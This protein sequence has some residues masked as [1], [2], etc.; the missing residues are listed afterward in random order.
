MDFLFAH[1]DGRI[2]QTPNAFTPINTIPQPP[3]VSP[4]IQVRNT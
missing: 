2:W 1:P 3:G 4:K